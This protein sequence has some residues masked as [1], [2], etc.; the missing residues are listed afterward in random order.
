[1][2]KPGSKMRAAVSGS[3]PAPESWTSSSTSP[4]SAA[5]T[6]RM[7]PSPPSASTA[8]RT[9]LRTS[10]SVSSRSPRNGSG[11]SGSSNSRRTEAGVSTLATSLARRARSISSIRRAGRCAYSANALQAGHPLRLSKQERERL[12]CAVAVIG[13]QPGD[14]TGENFDPHLDGSEAVADLVRHEAGGAA[15]ASHLLHFPQSGFSVRQT[16][17]H[18][19]E[20]IP[21]LGDLGKRRLAGIDPA[22][23]EVRVGHRSR[24]RIERVGDA[25]RE[26]TSQPDGP[27]RRDPR[28]QCEAR[29]VRSSEKTTDFTQPPVELYGSRRGLHA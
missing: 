1:V 10:R 16:R 24:E 18:G 20:C 4:R 21:Q 14:P 22:P 3:I 25:I 11:A 9:T 5:A 13:R 15:G 23:T 7:R 29:P 28:H 17:P 26:P 12:L 19:G 2:V 27:Q 8:L 6:T